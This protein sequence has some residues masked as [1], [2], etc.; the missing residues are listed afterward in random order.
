M[1]VLVIHGPNLGL[2]GEREPE[3]YG[4]D[5]LGDV[6]AYIEK[7]A[8]ELGMAVDIHQS[9]SE[10]RMI[11][12]LRGGHGKVQG[13]VLNPAVYSHLSRAIEQAIREAPY[14]VIEVHLSNIHAREPWRHRSVT[15]G[16]AAGVIAG[17]RSDSY[18]L[19]LRALHKLL[20]G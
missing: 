16:A 7:V 8:G 13:A 6:N 15:A 5:T 3:V 19:A 18:G 4:S 11:E 2:L 9:D 12:L 1:N 10:R 14:P 17:F 20:E